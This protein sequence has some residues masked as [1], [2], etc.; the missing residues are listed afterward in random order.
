[1]RILAIAVALSIS[2]AAARAQTT[3]TPIPF[4]SAQRVMAITPAVALRLKLTAPVWPVT[5]EYQEARLFAVSPGDAF[6]LVV[7]RPSGASDRFT[8]SPSDRD[9]LRS[10]IDAAMSATGRPSAEFG[11]DLVSEPAGNRLA[12]RLTTLAAVAY[13][14]LAASLTDSPEGAG[15]AWLLTT[16]LTFFASYQAAQSKGITRAQSD[17][18]GDLGLATG[19]GALLLG[20]SATGNADRGVRAVALGGAVVGTLVGGA[21]AAKLSDAEVHGAMLGLRMGGA[22]GLATSSLL[23]GNNRDGRSVAAASAVGMAIGYPLGLMY[24]RRASYLVTAGDAE[25]MATSGLIG[26]AWAAATLGDN[27][28]GGPRVGA[29]LGIG[30][31]VGGLV[32]SQVFARQFDLTRSQSTVLDVGAVAGALVGLAIPVLSDNAN[33][34]VT[35]ASA[36]GGATLGVA[37]LAGSFPLASKV[38]A[39][40]AGRLRRL[41]RAQVSVSPLSAIAFAGQTPGQYSLMNVRF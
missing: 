30:Y 33:N 6:T 28:P 34:A 35:W 13:G 11:A 7:H 21:S 32:G 18:A 4:D 10:A 36:A 38:G 26:A 8:L 5:G 15:A 24:P 2:S 1:M 3:E 12:I 40:V 22:L 9:A 14:P 27:N 39:P 41:G 23:A 16:G 25:A 29:T 20:Y 19:G 37:L 31:L 17:L